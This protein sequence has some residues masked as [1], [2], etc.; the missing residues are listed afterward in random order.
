L[1]PAL[2]EQRLFGVELACRA[3]RLENRQLHLKLGVGVLFSWVNS[4]VSDDRF[5]TIFNFIHHLSF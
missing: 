2:A 4:L 5:L 3:L 1:L